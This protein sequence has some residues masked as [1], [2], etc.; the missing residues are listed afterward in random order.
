MNNS[1]G[2]LFRITSFGESHGRCVGVIIDGC[3]AGLPLTAEDIQIEV[4]KRK[5]AVNAG[6]TAR[7]EED[8]VEI[9]S[10]VFHGYTTGAPI[11]LLVW[12]KDVNSAEYE[13]NEI[14]TA[15]RPCRLYRFFE[16]WRI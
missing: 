6:Q 12:N 15:A 4:D 5:P 1:F 10:G 3:P 16:I 8:K 11:G 9:L 13:K 2:E 7:A 14:F